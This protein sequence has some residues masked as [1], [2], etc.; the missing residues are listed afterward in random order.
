MR[1]EEIK[2]I[3]FTHPDQIEIN[4]DKLDSD[5]KYKQDF[6]DIVSKALRMLPMIE[7][8]YTKLING[9]NVVVEGEDTA[10]EPHEI[11]RYRELVEDELFNGY[12]MLRMWSTY[13]A[14][15]DVIKD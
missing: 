7:G 8:V 9:E 15:N 2:E 3:A 1:L 6:E 12:Q 14:V 10:L 13:L 11:D 4:W 5:P